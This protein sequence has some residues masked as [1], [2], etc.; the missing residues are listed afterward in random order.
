MKLPST[1]LRE[2]RPP[3]F[4]QDN[5]SNGDNLEEQPPSGTLT[6]PKVAK[7]AFEATY[8]DKLEENPELKKKFETFCK[9]QGDKENDPVTNTG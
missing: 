3:A 4:I 6:N 9:D 1:E 5:V 2:N 7:M 8:A